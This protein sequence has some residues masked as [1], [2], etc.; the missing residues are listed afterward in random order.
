MFIWSKL[1]Q[2]LS[3]IDVRAFARIKKVI[4]DQLLST[5]A[6][7]IQSFIKLYFCLRVK[8]HNSVL[9]RIFGRPG[10]DSDCKK[11]GSFN[12]KSNKLRFLNLNVYV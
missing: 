5:K 1:G 3:E 7:I 4:W 6:E 10:G 8:H 11:P 12:R 9:R 2:N